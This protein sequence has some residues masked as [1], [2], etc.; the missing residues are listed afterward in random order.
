MPLAL[1]R[2]V[3]VLFACLLAASGASAHETVPETW[4]VDAGT[5][6]VLVNKFD[7]DGATLRSM[8]DKCGIIEAIKPKDD[9]TAVAGT[10]GMYCATQDGGKNRET[11]M[12]FITGPDEYAAK[13]HHETYR[14]ETRALRAP[15]SSAC[16]SSA[17]T[18][19]CGASSAVVNHTM[20]S[21]RV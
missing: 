17:N 16:R 11:P 4:C 8:V 6:P 20:A 18:E 12:P 7:F 14:I 9:W 13:E 1:R 2:S 15:A 10:L 19:D 5:T 3:P 21:R